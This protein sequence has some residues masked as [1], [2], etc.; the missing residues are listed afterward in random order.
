MSYAS[1]LGVFDDTH[2][3]QAQY[4]NLNTIFYAG[5]IVAQV[6]GHVLIQRL[7]L[8]LFMAGSLFLWAALVLLHCTAHNY[9]GLICLRFFLG[10]VEA[11]LLPAIEITLGMFFEPAAQSTVQPVFWISCMGSPIPAGFLAYGLLFAHCAVPPWKLFMIITGGLTLLLA[12]FALVFY[13]SNPTEAH[14]LS[15]RERVHTVQRIHESTRSS[16]EQKHFRPYQFFEAL[17]DPVSWLFLV[18]GFAIMLAN[19]IQYQQNL[20]FVSLGVSNLGSTLVSVAG[21]GFA[22][23]CS[24]VAT[25]L[26]YFF[27]SYLAWWGVFWCLPSLAGSIAMVAL[28]WSDKLA[29]LAMLLLAGNTFGVTYIIGL[30]WTTSSA[31]G[32][33]KKMTRNAMFMVG[34]GVANII[35]PQFW[36][37]HTAPRYYPAWIVMIVVSFFVGPASLVVVR[38]ILKARNKERQAWI[39]EQRATGNYGKGVLERVQDEGVAWEQVDVSVLDLTDFENKFFLYPM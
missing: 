13:P 2:I 9:G 25:L 6:P 8:R 5:Y 31:A 15:T 26:I 1:I 29:L 17:R 18:N 27:P 22:V 36:V 30:G 10:L 7:P 19:N 14:F 38:Y 20:L 11:P 33:T 34:Y 32:Y 28:S 39:A 16:V 23:A 24:L 35:G 37:A 3:N 12:V 4:N 21:G